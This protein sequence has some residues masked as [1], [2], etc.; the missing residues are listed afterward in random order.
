ML[1]AMQGSDEQP[2]QFF[3]MLGLDPEARQVNIEFDPRRLVGKLRADLIAGDPS[4]APMLAALALSGASGAHPR[5]WQGLISISTTEPVV[6][7][8]EQLRL[9]ASRLDAFEKCPLHWFINNFGGDGQSF[10]ASI[11]TLLHAAMELATDSDSVGN[12]VESNW[13]TLKFET[14]WLAMAAKRRALKMVAY[15]SSYL[16]QSNYLVASEQGFEIDLGRLVV[17]GKIDR[18]ERSDQGLIAADLKTGKPPSAKETTEHRQLALYQLGLRESYDE[19]VAGGRIIS[20][21]SGSLKVLEQAALDGEFQKSIMA[22]LSEAES[23]IG[24]ASFVAKVSE[25]CSGDAKCQLLM[26]RAVT[27]V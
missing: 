25:H 20:V 3:Q 6:T 12:Y 13:H 10:E 5:N 4:A 7:A 9:S 2:S 26:A 15:I 17:A 14:E 19:P 23:Q 21:G 27:H 24:Q 11:G 18:V 1:S 22:L 16:S 8:D